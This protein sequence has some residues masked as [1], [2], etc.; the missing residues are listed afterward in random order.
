MGLYALERVGLEHSL[1]QG[2]AAFLRASKFTPTQVVGFDTTQLMALK[3]KPSL[4]E[5]YTTLTAALNTAFFASKVTVA[6]S[7]IVGARLIIGG[8]IERN[9]VIL[10]PVLPTTITNI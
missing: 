4:S 5:A 2:V 10:L 6:N 8:G 7:I 1:K 3:S 9:S